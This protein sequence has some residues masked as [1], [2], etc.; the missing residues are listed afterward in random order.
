MPVVPRIE[1]SA[2]DAQSG[3]HGFLGE[4]FATGNRDGNAC[5]D[6]R[7]HRFHV[8]GDLGAR[9]GIDRRLAD[10]KLQ[11]RQGHG[12]DTRPG[13]E[14]ETRARPGALDGD[15]DLGAMGDVGIVACVLDDSGPGPALA[16]LMASQCESRG[17]AA[18]QIDRHR[19]GKTESPKRRP[20]GARG[21]GGTG[22]R[23][24]A[25]AQRL[26]HGGTLSLASHGEKRCRFERPRL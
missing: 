5:I 1:K 16:L 6:R 18:R 11:A 7:A 21:A 15:D 13:D 25:L 9:R 19:I 10:G 24:P 17:H 26:L 20:G 4:Y 12:A 8:G 23:G 2:D 3:V 22:A 14:G